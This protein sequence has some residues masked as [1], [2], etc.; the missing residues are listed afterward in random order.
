[1]SR[2]LDRVA[3]AAS[4]SGLL[5]LDANDYASALLAN[6]APPW[7][8]VAATLAWQRKAQGLLRSDVVSL[9]L[10]VVIDAWLAQNPALRTAM[11]AKSRLLAPLKV[12]LADE[13]LRAHLAEMVRGMRAGFG[14]SVLALLI[15]SPR[16]WPALSYA[17]AFGADQPAEV[18]A[19][20]ADAASVYI[21][22]FLRGFGDAGVDAL[23][24][25]EIAASVPSCDDDLSCYGAVINV[26]RNY[27]W[28]IGLLQP[29]VGNYD[30]AS[31]DFVIAPEAQP[32][33]PIA[34]LLLPTSIWQ[35]GN[36]SAA[37]LRY[38]GVPATGL[39]PEAVL[40]R[41]SALRGG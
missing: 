26:A 15:P 23:L 37:S 16:Y 34:A 29:A 13:A 21:A 7:L 41:L 38:L 30:A 28:D 1:M 18:T 3:S 8:D 6:G 2:L 20:D 22:D 10:A 12:L 27:R 39:Q 5:W 36:A 32:G 19:D 17:Q 14:D 31:V 40:E 25:D 24:L 9:P 4:G 35:G 33:A 11:A